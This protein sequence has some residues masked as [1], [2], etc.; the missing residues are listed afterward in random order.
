MSTEVIVIIGFVAL[1]VYF[2]IKTVKSK[3]GIFVEDI[4]S[5]EEYF[6][7]KTCS[8]PTSVDAFCLFANQLK[9]SQ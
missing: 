8:P 3:H 4:L 1:F 9:N 5:S 2:V 6:P 7:K